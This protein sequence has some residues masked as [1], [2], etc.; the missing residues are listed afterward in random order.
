VGDNAPTTLKSNKENI[1]SE[2]EYDALP[3]NIKEILNAHGFE[4][5]YDTCKAVQDALQQVGWTC[6]YD[7]GGSIFD[8]KE[9][10]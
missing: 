3:E 6:D 9:K 10:V 4:N 2:E 1:M 8:V 7:L 5:D